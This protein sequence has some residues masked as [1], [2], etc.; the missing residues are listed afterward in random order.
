MEAADTIPVFKYAGAVITDWDSD[1]R[2]DLVAEA[3]GLALAR[4]SPAD[5]AEFGGAA[6]HAEHLLRRRFDS[7]M[8]LEMASKFVFDETCEFM[9]HTTGN[10]DGIRRHAER[11][12]Q[13]QRVETA[14]VVQLRPVGVQ[15]TAISLLPIINGNDLRAKVKTRPWFLVPNMFQGRKVSMLMGEDGAGKSFLLLMLAVAIA[16]GGYWLG[17]KMEK[18]PVIFYTAEEEEADINVRLDAIEK[19]LD[20]GP[21]DLSDLHIIPMGGEETSVLGGPVS[22]G[23][24]EATPLWKSLVGNIEAFRPRAI[25]IDPLNE[26]FDGDELKR[27]QARQF[28]GLMRPVAAR[29]DLAIIVAGHPSKTGVNERSGTSG[30]T[31]WSA[32]FR[33]RLYLEKV[34]ADDNV[35]D[36]G[37]RLLTVKKLTGGKRFPPIDLVTGE[38]GVLVRENQPVVVEGGPFDLTAGLAAFER[39]HQE[40]LDLVVK[41][42][43]QGRPLS[44]NPGARNYAPKVIAKAEGGKEKGKRAAVLERTMNKLFDEKRLFA[45]VDGYPS[46]NKKKLS[47]VAEKAFKKSENDSAPIS[48]GDSPESRNA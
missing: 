42:E 24:I 5:Q 11:R 29:H 18:G 15:Q 40:F 10:W 27:V 14:K 21:L 31:G 2:R 7:G 28:V 22:G 19:M 35:T 26:V 34:L 16:T 43:E 25:V 33:A 46:D 1:T 32:V 9:D 8:D 38:D 6:K 12:R 44:P 45:V 47:L 39:E 37:K 3:A 13:A 41:Y 23:K 20:C 4:Y 17:I 48:K 30:S 36:T